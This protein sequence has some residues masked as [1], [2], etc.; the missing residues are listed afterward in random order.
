MAGF[1]AHTVLNK[2]MLPH[3]E[4]YDWCWALTGMDSSYIHQ[5]HLSTPTR[6]FG[7]Q[8]IH[9]T[10]IHFVKPAVCP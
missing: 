5:I 6:K 3:M 2:C 9:V 1:P 7:G 4:L 8:I 10:H